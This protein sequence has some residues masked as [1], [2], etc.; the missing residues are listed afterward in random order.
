M[1]TELTPHQ[2]LLAQVLGLSALVEKLTAVVVH[3]CGT[4]AMF[5]ALAESAGDRIDRALPASLPPDEAEAFR[6]VARQHV[7]AMVATAQLTRKGPISNER[8]P[9]QPPGA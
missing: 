6:A 5:R 8:P 9:P 3:S 1:T 2:R 7:D 4:E